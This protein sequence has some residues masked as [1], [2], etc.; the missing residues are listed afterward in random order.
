M[1]SAQ[2]KSLLDQANSNLSNAQLA[3]ED[4]HKARDSVAAEVASGSVDA[5]S[6]LTAVQ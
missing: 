3:L 4:A 2:T 1:D 5:V 6:R